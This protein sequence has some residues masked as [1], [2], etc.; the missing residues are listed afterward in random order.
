ME[1]EKKIDLFENFIKLRISQNI[2]RSNTTNG[3]RWHIIYQYTPICKFLFSYYPEFIKINLINSISNDFN[4]LSDYNKILGCVN[5][6]CCYGI[7]ERN[8]LGSNNIFIRLKPEIYN[9]FNAE[10]GKDFIRKQIEKSN[11]KRKPM[12][13]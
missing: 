10:M 5:R 4:D 11:E 12:E 6:L 9:G 8:I 13:I 7:L 2:C 3:I 1:K